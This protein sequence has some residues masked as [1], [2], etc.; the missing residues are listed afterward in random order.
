MTE[1]S[2]RERLVA[3]R[4]ETLP[5]PGGGDTA[6]RHRRLM[7]VGREDLTLAKLMEAHWD[8]VA[9]LAEAKRQPLPGAVY[10]VWASEIPGEGL[11]VERG[12]NELR[13]SGA[14][15]FCSG[16][17]IVERALVS[18]GAPEFL[19]LEVDVR[20]S[21]DVTTDAS[22][23]MTGAFRMT[24]TA[25]VTFSGARV[26]AVLGGPRWYVERAGF[27]NGACGPAACWAGGALGLVD[28]ALRSKRAD[29]H[30]LA[31][32][33]AMQAN[34]WAM[35]SWLATA[36]AGIDAAPGDAGAAQVRA[37]TVRHLV[38]QACTDTLRRFARAYG[39]QPLA[40][41][42]EV[43]RRYQELDLYM[44]QSHAERDLEE[45]GR[46]LKR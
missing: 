17:G 18:T 30:T 12:E 2:L 25:T 13:V 21:A 37:L 11:Q 36:G 24:Q 8:A 26:A 38:E 27:W 40:M 7:E 10:G 34:A 29:A 32:L 39:P 6:E 43:S 28:V 42:A 4:D 31:H 33:G 3:L 23:W 22:G 15:Q 46:A 35:Q 45:L 41:N 16:A 44:R 5:L 14:K 20:P 9:L 1:A 19:L